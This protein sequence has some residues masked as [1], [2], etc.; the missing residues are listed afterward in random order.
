MLNRIVKMHFREEAV[1]EFLTVFYRYH[2]AIASQS[3]C[4][5]VSLLQ[6][7]GQKNVFYTFSLWDNAESLDNYRQSALFQE[8]WPQTKKLFLEPARAWSLYEKSSS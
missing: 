3:G 4:Q 5:S 1:E 7:H 8:V 6:D 2:A